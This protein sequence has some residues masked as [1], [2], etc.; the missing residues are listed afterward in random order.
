MLFSSFE[1]SP[2]PLQFPCLFYNEENQQWVKISV[3]IRTQFLCSLLKDV[4]STDINT[5]SNVNAIINSVK[6]NIF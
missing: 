4:L 2:K 3:T 6:G 5:V 1:P